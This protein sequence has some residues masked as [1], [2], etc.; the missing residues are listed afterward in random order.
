MAWGKASD[1]ASDIAKEATCKKTY[2]SYLVKFRVC[3]TCTKNKQTKM[4]M[5]DPQVAG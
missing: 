4:L 2:D 5:A 1:T 3:Y